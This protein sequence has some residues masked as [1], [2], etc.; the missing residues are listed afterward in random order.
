MYLYNDEYIFGSHVIVGSATILVYEV[1][2][3]L[4]DEINYIWMQ[5][6]TLGTFLF[7]AN[8]YLPFVDVTLGMY[9]Q[10][11]AN[12]GPDTCDKY[13][14][15]ILWAVATGLFIA[16]LI[17]TLRTLAIWSHRRS[18]LIFLSLMTLITSGAGI[19]GVVLENHSFQFEPPPL[20]GRGCKLIKSR[21]LI[22][23]PYLTVAISETS[24]VCLT[25]I[26]ALDHFRRLTRYSWVTRVYGYG[27][28]FYIYLLLITAANIAIPFAAEEPR[29]KGYFA[30]SQHVFHSI[31]CTRVI[32][33]IQ[34]RRWARRSLPHADD[35][36]LSHAPG[37]NV[38][39]TK[40]TVHQHTSAGAP[41]T[42]YSEGDVET[43]EYTT[44]GKES[45]AVASR[46][47]PNL[48]WTQ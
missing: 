21:R 45:S 47:Q 34:R 25:I 46:A 42:T 37:V 35:G 3:T 8:R 19:V 11:G 44:G 43:A 15:G 17:I 4:D 1:L 23:I 40:V 39:M 9:V 14:R 29:Y 48:D 7:W 2:T 41:Y 24:V 32:V 26:R 38:P 6:W 28:L 5:P 22:I 13:Y 12:I 30:I 20:G 33:L 31:F 36:S 18:I 27:L 10:F 16:E